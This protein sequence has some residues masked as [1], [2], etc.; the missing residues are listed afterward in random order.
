MNR[1]N[2]RLGPLLKALLAALLFG[3]SAPLAKSL[4]QDV[5]PVPMAALL[6]LGSGTGVLLIALVFRASKGGA[7][8][9]PLARR[10]LPWLTGAVIAGGIAAPIVLM[11][12][13]TATP[14]GTASL[15]LNFEGVATALIA[16]IVFREAIGRPAWAAVALVTLGSIVLSWNASGAWG[17]SLGALGVVAACALWGLDNNLTRPISGKNPLTI[18][19]VKGLAAG[20]FSLV[21]RSRFATLCQ[22]SSRPSRSCCSA[23]SATDSAP[24]SSFRR[25]AI[26]AP[27]GPAPCTRRRRFSA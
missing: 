19:M 9:A 6:Y 11:F 5:Q 10:D 14:A 7:T 4:L 17:F 20:T 22:G 23:A 18:V 25:C 8:E 13:L 24:R 21:R 2:S 1:S 16:A 12:S 26:S 3:A 15:L 27:P